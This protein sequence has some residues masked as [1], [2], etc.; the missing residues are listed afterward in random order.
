MNTGL[1]G[2]EAAIDT[3][4]S[5]GYTYEGGEMWKPPIGACKPAPEAWYDMVA[6]ARK[7]GNPDMAFGTLKASTILEVDDVIQ[8]L[9]FR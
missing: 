4:K 1:E 8:G 3:L 7:A 5:L 2:A 9:K 6:W